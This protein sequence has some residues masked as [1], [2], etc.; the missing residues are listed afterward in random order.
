MPSASYLAIGVAA[1]G[2][3][4]QLPAL[5][6]VGGAV[7]AG[8]VADGIVADRLAVVLRQQVAPAAVVDIGASLQSGRRKDPVVKA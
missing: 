8:H 5:P 4:R 2:D 6:G 1:A 7:V 3:L